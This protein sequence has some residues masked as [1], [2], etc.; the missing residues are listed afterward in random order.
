MF[1]KDINEIT[2]EDL[3][4]LVNNEVQED[5]RLE[6][7][8]ELDLS[9]NEHKRKLLKTVCAFSNTSGGLLIYGIKENNGFP[10]ELVGLDFNPDKE[11]PQV[12]DIIK[13]RFEPPISLF[14]PH[15]V[16]LPK[17]GPK[18]GKKALIIKF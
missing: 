18:T 14:E 13:A 8:G 3:E 11:I 16:D 2:E 1:E 15:S 4:S 10:E 12:I 17:T 5:R 7:K 9:N 6:Y